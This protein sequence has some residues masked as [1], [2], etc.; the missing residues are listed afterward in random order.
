MKNKAFLCTLIAIL[1]AV[2]SH[3][4]VL[5]ETSNPFQFGSMVLVPLSIL[6]IVLTA[7]LV[8]YYTVKRRRGVASK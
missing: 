2:S 8:V 5:T 1:I 7:G 4:E 6:A 3:A